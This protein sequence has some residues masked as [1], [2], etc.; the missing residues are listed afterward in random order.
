MSTDPL[1]DILADLREEDAI[2]TVTNRLAAGADHL[3]ILD[4]CRRAMA[5]VGQR[6]ENKEYFLPDLIMAG[7][8]LRQVS[9]LIKPLLHTS[10]ESHHLGTVVLGTVQGDIHYIGKN[11]VKFMLEA[12]GFEV[13]D[14]GEDVPPQRF[15]EAIDTIQPQ[16]V[17]MSGL[18]TIVFDAIKETIDAITAAGLRDRVKIMIGGS[19]IDERVRA[20]TGA[21][22]YGSDAMVAVSLAKQ[23]IGAE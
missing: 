5:I 1:I 2:I 4:S 15:V 13:H 21:D 8:I 17:G 23:W 12:N 18:L 22:A 6:F 3:Q 11:L 19:Q 14:L 9:E 16:I 10:S 7:E 20:Y